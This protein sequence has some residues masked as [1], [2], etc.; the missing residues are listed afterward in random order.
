MAHGTVTATL[1]YLKRLPLYQTEKPFQLFL[2]AQH[3]ATDQ[4]LSNLEFEGRETRIVDIRPKLSTFDLD[5]HGFQILH[6]PTKLAPTCFQDP[7]I[8]ESLYFDEVVNILKKLP[9]GYD[10]VFLFDWRVVT[11]VPFR[12][13][14]HSFSFSLCAQLKPSSDHRSYEMLKSCQLKKD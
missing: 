10:R 8:V 2:P 7:K 12:F 14:L 4:R 6:A 11:G 1:N 3:H 9:G 5:E 13:D